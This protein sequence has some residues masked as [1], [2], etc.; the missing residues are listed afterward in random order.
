M[1]DKENHIGLASVGFASAELTPGAWEAMENTQTRL[2]ALL[3]CLCSGGSSTQEHPPL[4]V[5][6]SV[7]CNSWCLARVYGTTSVVQS[8]FVY[9]EHKYSFVSFFLLCHR[10]LILTN[11]F[12]MWVCTKTQ[13]SQLVYLALFCELSHLLYFGKW[14][15]KIPL[16]KISF[17][18]TMAPLF[19]LSSICCYFLIL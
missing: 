11:V 18:S 9:A 15:L 5:L 17:F 16:K 6:I 19:F 8:T 7:N 10:E 4:L 14:K 12:I 2:S 13:R 3:V 1:L